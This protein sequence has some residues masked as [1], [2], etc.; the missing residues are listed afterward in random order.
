M[1]NINSWK[2]IKWPEIEKV[3]FRLQLRIYKAATNNE[4][5]K[6][7]KLQRTL[8]KS[9]Y[10][11]YLAVRKVTQ[12]NS[13][14]KTAGVDK[15][16]VIK[17]EDKFN[18]A[19]QIILDGKTSP[20]K[21]V[22]IPKSDGSMRPLGIPTIED[23]SKQMLAYFAL[24][25]QWEAKFE[26][27][28]YGF[29]PGRS[30]QDAIE[31]VHKGI[32][33]RSKWVL[34]ADIEKC[35]DRINHQYLIDKC[36]TFP[37]MSKQIRSWLKAGILEGG[38]YAFPEM[39][40]PQGGVISP[41]LANIALHGIRQELDSYIKTLPGP[42]IPNQNSLTYIRYADDFI[43]M[44]PE[45][46][47]LD[48]LKVVIEEFLE[49]IGLK[50]H[51]TK[52][53]IVHTKDKNGKLPPGFSFLGFDIVQKQKWANMR[54]A[55]TKVQ[56]KQ[57]FITLIKPSKEGVK[58][59]K[60]KLR[61]TIRKYRAIKQEELIYQ[62]NPIIRGWALSKRS[63]ISSEIFQELDKYVFIHLWKWARRRHP[64]MS[65]YKLKDKYWHKI[66]KENWVFGVK[67]DNEVIK[68]LQLHSKIKIQRHIKVRDTASPFDGNLNYWAKRTGKS[69]LIPPIKARLIK[70][71][72]N[73][74]GLCGKYFLPG[75]IIE[76]D[77]IVPKYQGGKNIRSNVHAVH[78][79]C[80]LKKSNIERDLARR[81][82][83]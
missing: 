26:A 15:I 68:R 18:L 35:F 80:H 65:K 36:E 17:P 59:H 64:K 40:T 61:E 33:R 7:H 66:G 11:K 55:F 75:E 12:D 62:L 46:E 8:I 58:K 37:E 54:R 9:K 20:I 50:L 30:V 82:N 41:L 73:C 16:I 27:G 74:C 31:A 51:S 1:E 34:D 28:S 79:Y 47:T 14:K 39:V 49:P 3:V 38:A 6:L 29:R 72:N 71:Q 56:T 23:R 5:E 19:E 53:K 10:A 22:Y 42:T 2:D 69:T 83:N 77:H 81:I 60:S 70:E 32:N 78:R 57:N 67:S 52:T 63:Q 44:Y 21:R 24:T 25:P 4:F 45:R 48:K 76:R 13:G 43:I